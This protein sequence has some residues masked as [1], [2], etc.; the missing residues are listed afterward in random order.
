MQES[1]VNLGHPIH[2][3]VSARSFCAYVDVDGVELESCIFSLRTR[4]VVL[5][6]GSYLPS[7]PVLSFQRCVSKRWALSDKLIH[8]FLCSVLFLFERM[9]CKFFNI[10]H[11][12][13]QDHTRHSVKPIRAGHTWREVRKGSTATMLAMTIRKASSRSRFTCISH[14]FSR[15]L[16]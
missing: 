12:K 8:R 3:P 5:I 6:T 16:M 14:V 15:C 9:N 4:E 2:V 10:V 1:L 11:V 7:G 13:D